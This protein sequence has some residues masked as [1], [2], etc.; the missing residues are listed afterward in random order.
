M[1]DYF[2]KFRNVVFEKRG[3]VLCLRVHTDGQPL[4]WGSADGSVHD[5]LGEVFHAIAHDFSV[6]AV[7]MT[8]TGDNFCMDRN[9]N[10][11]EAFSTQYWRRIAREGRDLMMN[12]LDIEVPV[13]TAI[14]GPCHF[15]P[16][17][18]VM[19]DVVLCVPNTTFSD[20]HLRANIVAGDGCHVVWKQLLGHSRGNY[21]LLME[22]AL[23]AE[24]AKNFGVVHEI[25]PH[26]QLMDRAWAIADRLMQKSD[27]SLRYT[28]ALFT[29][30]LK[31]AMIRD[32]EYG[33]AVEG[34]EFALRNGKL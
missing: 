32:L 15:H 33:L 25:V 8:G 28:R 31:E 26:D 6:R 3:D 34:L 16:E 4:L 21:F 22:E 12:L 17:L 11:L 10:E 1:S 23:S 18:C 20:S 24:D 2:N 5:Q 7:I 14:N 29:R 30:P 27:V 19:A 9:N 13:I